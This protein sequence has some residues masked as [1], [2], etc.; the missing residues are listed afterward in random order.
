MDKSR[1][2]SIILHYRNF[3]LSI[4]LLSLF[5]WWFFI[6]TPLLS[7]LSYFRRACKEAK[8]QIKNEPSIAHDLLNEKIAYSQ[9]MLQKSA[10]QITGKFSKETLSKDILLIVDRSKV[11]LLF[12]R[13]QPWQEKKYNQSCFVEI[14]VDGSFA[15]CCN[16]LKYL[17]LMGARL[18]SCVIEADGERIKII[19]KIMIIHNKRSMGLNQY[20]LH[21]EDAFSTMRNIFEVY[22]KQKN[23]KQ[24]MHL[25]KTSFLNNQISKSN[26]ERFRIFI[27]ELDDIEKIPKQLASQIDQNDIVV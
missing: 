13:T 24:N 8:R 6:Y 17:T 25:Q 1:F 15:A 14:G 20:D 2:L 26:F 3:L 22:A 19:T 10:L 11:T 9:L 4:L 18:K 21:E 7:Q 23:N 5:C 16:F 12:L 27:P